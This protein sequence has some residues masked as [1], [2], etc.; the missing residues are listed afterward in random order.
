MKRAVT[1]ASF[2]A[3]AIGSGSAGRFGYIARLRERA[4]CKRLQGTMRKFIDWYVTQH[5]CGLVF[6]RHRQVLKLVCQLMNLDSCVIDSIAGLMVPIGV[7]ILLL[8]TTIG[9][10][11]ANSKPI[12]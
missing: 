10:A 1:R 12:S 5:T 7:N 11:S 3:E 8:S 6:G 9:D 4:V 2:G